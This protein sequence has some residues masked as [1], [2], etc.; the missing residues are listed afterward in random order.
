MRY[1]DNPHLNCVELADLR[2]AINEW[3]KAQRVPCRPRSACLDKSVAAA[4]YMADHHPQLSSDLARL[5]SSRNPCLAFFSYLTL[6]WSGAEEA[7][8]C[9]NQLAARR[10]PVLDG[11]FLVVRD[12]DAAVQAAELHLKLY[13]SEQH[14]SA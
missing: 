2:G 4:R 3:R 9:R 8:S 11:C 5:A 10:F 7:A 12:L 14:P 1:I 13:G 6:L